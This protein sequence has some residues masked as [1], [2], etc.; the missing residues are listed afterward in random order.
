MRVQERLYCCNANGDVR[1]YL[2]DKGEGFTYF[3]G[4]HIFPFFSV[5]IQTLIINSI[6]FSLAISLN[7][8]T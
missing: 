2:T 4:L 8:I 5:F 3:K 7:K 6:K 1:D